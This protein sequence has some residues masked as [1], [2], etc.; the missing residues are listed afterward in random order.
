MTEQICHYYLLNNIL[1]KYISGA[2]KSPVIYFN[3]ARY[4]TFPFRFCALIRNY[5]LC[6][7]KLFCCVFIKH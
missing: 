2:M 7:Y 1:F 3:D 4:P 5:K 6:V